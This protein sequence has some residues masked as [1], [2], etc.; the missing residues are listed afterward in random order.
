M[1]VWA[2]GAGLASALWFAPASLGI[3]VGQTIFCPPPVGHIVIAPAIIPR[4][5]RGWGRLS[6]IVLFFEI[7]RSLLRVCSLIFIFTNV[8]HRGIMSADKG[9]DMSIENRL[10]YLP[11]ISLVGE[12]IAID[13]EERYHV[14]NVLRSKVGDTLRATDGRGAFYQCRIVS[15]DKK[16][17]SVEI[18]T[19]EIAPA[20]P[21][22]IHLFCAV[23][24]RDKFEWLIEKAVESGIA[25]ITPII[26]DRNREYA[27]KEK[28]ERYEKIAAVALKQSRRPFMP[29]LQPLTT[30]KDA[31]P[32]MKGRIYLLSFDGTPFVA[33]DG[34]AGDVSLCIGPEGGFTVDEERSIA[35]CGAHARS[36]GTYTLKTET[37][38]L[39]ALM[40]LNHYGGEF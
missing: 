29:A 26:C 4:C 23:T 5:G 13:D 1:G 2:V 28:H 25:S 11:N 35:E 32:L 34:L 16:T 14:V 33:Q 21:L 24:K 38:A 3:F 31:L 27:K 37:A 40:L 8:T 30:I 6:N 15:I 17:C 39:K 12:T 19:K 7:L 18:T 20:Y 10:F 22:R 36:F 9:D